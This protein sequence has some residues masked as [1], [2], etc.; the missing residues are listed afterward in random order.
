[1]LAFSAER[2]VSLWIREGSSH[3][4]CEG[5]MDVFCSSLRCPRCL[6]LAGHDVV[7]RGSQLASVDLSPAQFQRSKN[8]T[9]QNLLEQVTTSMDKER[10]ELCWDPLHATVGKSLS[11]AT[12]GPTVHQGN[13]GALGS[14]N[15]A[16]V[17]LAIDPRTRLCERAL[18][19]RAREVRNSHQSRKAR[20]SGLRKKKRWTSSSLHACPAPGQKLK[21]NVEGVHTI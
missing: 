20:T 21:H 11:K 7:W 19:Y 18:S 9:P 12:C 6:S 17:L 1:M 4:R 5:T 15:S 3:D 16:E 13:S 14:Q 2:H 8:I 10:Y